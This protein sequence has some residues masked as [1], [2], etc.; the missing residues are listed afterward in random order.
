MSGLLFPISQDIDGL[1]G[2]DYS[3][4]VVDELGFLSPEVW[5][6]ML[7]RSGKRARS[8]LWGTGTPGLDR[9]NALWYVRQSVMEGRQPTS[10]A[11]REYAADPGCDL[12][13]KYQWY[14]ANPA[15]AAG[16]MR[17]TGLAAAIEQMPEAMHVSSV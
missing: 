15:L 10:L 13:D 8:L 11:W 3:F 14:K 5:S 12:R 7:A 17:E 16:F 9:N 2:L 4:A 1:Q 6:S